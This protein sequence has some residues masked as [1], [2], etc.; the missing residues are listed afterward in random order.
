MKAVFANLGFI[1]QA[2]GIIN[3]LA[4]PVAIIYDE[5][6]ALVSFLIT[7]VVFLAAGF[8]MNSLSQRRRFDFKS[9]C[10]LMTLVFTLLG[11]GGA[12]PF[13]YTN[14]FAGAD[15]FTKIAASIF[16]SVSGYTTSGFSMISDVDALPRSMVFYRGLTQWI[17]GIGVVFVILVFFNSRHSLD[18]VGKAVGF[19]KMTTTMRRS[20]VVILLIYAAYTAVFFGLLWVFGLRDWVVNISLVFSTIAT[21]GFGPVNDVATLTVF[22]RGLILDILMI[23]GATSFIVHYRLFT[24]KFKR[25]L[26]AELVTMVLIMVAF[27]FVFSVLTKTNLGAS[28]FHVISVSS[29]TGASYINLGSLAVNA[30]SLLF[31]LMFIGGR[32]SS[33]A[34]GIR[35]VN[36]L[37]FVKSIPW[38]VKS[39]ITGIPG[40]FKLEEKEYSVSDVVTALLAIILAVVLVIIFAFVFTLFGHSL[41]DSLFE[42]ISAFANTGLSVGIANLALPNLLK[43]ILIITMLA[44]RVGIVALLVAL[45]PGIKKE[46]DRLKPESVSLSE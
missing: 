34:G 13:L 22:P 23:L 4:I 15:V 24:G 35:I 11:V 3:L 26:S 6:S 29:T 44:G 38:A 12:I 7:S 39:L 20:F 28:F 37:V 46:T 30:K 10:V 5:Q 36:V 17:G 9:S 21:G 8:G 19:E 32:A 18:N 25:V 42:V 43:I 40:N 41:V 1:L 16:E 31:I 33:T 2:T 45:I 27:S 14:T